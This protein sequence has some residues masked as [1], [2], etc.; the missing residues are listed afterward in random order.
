MIYRSERLEFLGECFDCVTL[1]PDIN[2]WRTSHCQMTKPY[3]TDRRISLCRVGPVTHETSW[4]NFRTLASRPHINLKYGVHTVSIL[5]YSL[6]RAVNEG[7]RRCPELID[8][9][10]AMDCIRALSRVLPI[11]KVSSWNKNWNMVFY[12]WSVRWF[13]AYIL[14]DTRGN[15]LQMT[16][17]ISYIFKRLKPRI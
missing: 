8:W 9:R 3:S 2:D 10:H 6:R 11:A 15:R 14:Q 7:W 17:I 16:T 4:T 13:C 1:K 5:E 12:S